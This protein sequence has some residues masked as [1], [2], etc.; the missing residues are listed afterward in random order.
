MIE[1]I[2]GRPE[3]MLEAKLTGKLTA[4]DYEAVLMPAIEE[5]LWD[6]D[7]IRFLAQIGPGFDGF[8]GAAA[9]DDLRLGL[10][11]WRGFDRIAL[12]TDV[13]WLET[14]ARA[15]A[16]MAPCPVKVFPLEKLSEA[17]LWL[18]ESLGAV[19]M[20]DL[21]AGVLQIQLLGQLDAAVYEGANERL[22]AFVRDNDSVRFLLD[23]R[24]FDGWLG[25]SA[26]G[27]HFSLVRDH[28]RIPEKIAFVGTKDWQKMAER[29]ASRFFAAE[30]EYFD[31]AQ[32]EAAKVWLKE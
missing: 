24:E 29:I 5:A 26:L 7:S 8:T 20:Q 13:G 12:V 19:H 32:I 30:I 6:R 23:L 31:G 9:L 18:S 2:D 27:Q 21:G 4:E 1:I 15:M 28:H 11:H 22:D 14:A 16:F 25:I 17:R 3:G 10:R